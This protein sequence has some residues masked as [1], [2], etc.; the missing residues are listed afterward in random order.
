MGPFGARVV[1]SL[2]EAAVSW[3]ECLGGRSWPQKGAGSGQKKIL[4]YARPKGWLSAI[5]RLDPE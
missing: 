2:S 4:D 3:R 1:I 5:G